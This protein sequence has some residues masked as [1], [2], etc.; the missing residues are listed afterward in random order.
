MNRLTEVTPKQRKNVTISAKV[1]QACAYRKS[2][3]RRGMGNGYG[4]RCQFDGDVG[5]VDLELPSLC[6]AR[7]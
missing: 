7:T 3:Q 4:R 5:A 6:A 2:S 1:S